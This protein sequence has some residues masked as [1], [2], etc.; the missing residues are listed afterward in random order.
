LIA[1][2]PDVSKAPET[3]A[4]SGEAAAL[5]FEK[6]WNK[7]LAAE[8]LSLNKLQG[9][10]IDVLDLFALA[11]RDAAFFAKAGIAELNAPCFASAKPETACPSSF[12]SDTLHPTAAAHRLIAIEALNA[13]PVPGS[14]ALMLAGLSALLLGLRKKSI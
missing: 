11:Q 6:L 4:N 12:F 1:N 8:I 5:E 3:K 9:I 10:D 2:M 14:L 13:I 7:A